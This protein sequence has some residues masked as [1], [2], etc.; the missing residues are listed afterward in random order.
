MHLVFFIISI[1][2]FIFFICSLVVIVS[3]GTCMK[4]SDT[5]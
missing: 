5:H 4:Y 3:D 2:I 1:F